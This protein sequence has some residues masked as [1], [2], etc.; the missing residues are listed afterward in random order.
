MDG[1]YPEGSFFAAV[2]FTS[3]TRRGNPTGVVFAHPEWGDRTCQRIAA[4]LGFPDTVFLQPHA[5]HANGWRARFFSPAQPL[6]LCV[7]ALIA[8]GAVLARADEVTLFTDAGAT[9]VRSE[10]GRVWAR[11]GREAVKAPPEH[12]LE[13]LGLGLPDGP[14]RVIDSGRVRR[15]QE[16]DGREALATLTLAPDEVLSVCRRQGLQGLC[17]WTRVDAQTVALRVFTPSLDGG[18]D[19]STGGAVLGLSALL[20]PGSWR[21][22]QGQGPFHR[23]GELW[24]RAGESLE[25]GGAVRVIASGMLADF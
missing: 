4:E 13:P 1:F 2:A 12:P 20:P 14:A 23:L 11:F 24:L 19:A 8:C 16:V 22:E 25:V 7:Q 9:R 5:P 15:F 3:A 18:E 6:S 17:F 10:D 21:V